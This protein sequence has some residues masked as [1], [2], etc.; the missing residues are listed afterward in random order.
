MDYPDKTTD[1]TY[2][3]AGNRH[4]EQDRDPAGTLLADKLYTYD[5]RNRLTAVTDAVDPSRDV[6]YGFDLNGNQTSRTPASGPA[7]DFVFNVRD[8]LIRV[9]EDT[10]PVGTYR[11][12]ATGLRVSK[13]TAEGEAR[14]VYDDRS[15]LVRTD[16]AGVTKFEY[17]PDRLLSTHHPTEGRAYYLF[18]ALGS[19]VDLTTPAGALLAQYQWDAW[20]NLRSSTET[21][22]NP[23]GFTGHEM[24]GEA[25]LIYARAR[26]YDPVTG[27]FLSHDPAAGEP[28]N[29]PSLHRYLYAYQ[30]PTV[31]VDP[32]GERVATPDQ[33]ARDMGSLVR[34]RSK[35]AEK[36]ATLDRYLDRL[37]EK[38]P[39]AN[40]ALL[41]GRLQHGVAQAQAE[42][43]EAEA[44]VRVGL[45][46]LER[47]QII[48]ES[49]ESPIAQKEALVAFL[50]AEIGNHT[51]AV[52]LSGAFTPALP[53]RGYTC[54][55]LKEVGKHAPAI[56]MM[57]VGLLNAVLLFGGELL[58]GGRAVAGGRV[59]TPMR[60]ADDVAEFQRGPVR[61]NRT[62]TARETRS[63]PKAPAPSGVLPETG[64]VW[65]DIYPTQPSYPGSEI[66][67]SFELQAGNQR[68]WVHGN[69]TEHIAEFAAVR[70]RSY[71]PEY[72]RLV[73]QQQLRSLQSAVRRATEEGVPF[74]KTIQIEGWE[75]RFAR[76]RGEGELPA[77]IHAQPY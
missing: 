22:A 56:E 18:D 25:G 12:D 61:I 72:V 75:L 67:R 20:G 45:A 27:R 54:E 47:V 43:V 35:M 1:Y 31:Y 38:G 53:C 24:D 46:F 55:V 34:A 23:F 36:Q 44:R 29:P 30:N 50:H 33:V 64:T 73:S 59:G 10:L 26:F 48:L 11:Y 77:L 4:T 49:E 41:L 63:A 39:G 71:T 16:A 19:V 60:L 52:K 9:E 68:V 17:G 37:R 66:P 28:S 69:A 3:G 70:A 51:K 5:D 74:G 8:Q 7:V 40:E 21:A 2:D 6:A 62:A 65:D 32:T 57:E 13:F 76:P 15:V 14:Y 58:A 42:L